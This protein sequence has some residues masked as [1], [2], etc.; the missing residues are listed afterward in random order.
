MLN[1]SQQ[2]NEFYHAEQVLSEDKALQTARLLLVDSVRQVL[3]NGLK[4]LGIAAPD[5]M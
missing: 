2:F 1:L 5:E 3:A 4:L